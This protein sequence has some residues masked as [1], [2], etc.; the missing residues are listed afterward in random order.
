MNTTLTYALKIIHVNISSSEY[1]FLEYFTE[2]MM[3]FNV[4]LMGVW[5]PSLSRYKVWQTVLCDVIR[6]MTHWVNLFSSIRCRFR[7]FS[8]SVRMYS[9]RIP[10]SKHFLRRHRLQNRRFD[11]SILHFSSY[12]H[13]KYS[14]KTTDVCLQRSMTIK[15]K[16]YFS[17]CINDLMTAKCTLREWLDIM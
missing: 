9:F 16:I 7:I 17:I 8:S 11:T 6:T 10:I 2:V 12:G 14:W 5:S 15:P 13:L 1:E 3:I 4:N